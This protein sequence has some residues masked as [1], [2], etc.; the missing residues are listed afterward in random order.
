AGAVAF[1]GGSV[2]ISWHPPAVMSIGVA[3]SHFEKKI[4]TLG[5]SVLAGQL[6]LFEKMGEDEETLD[7][8]RWYNLLG[9]PSLNMR[10]S[11]PLDYQV[12][13]V[14]AKSADL[15]KLDLTAMDNS[16]NA[17]AGLT[18]AVTTTQR[19]IIAVG[20]TQADGKASLS[21]PSAIALGSDATLTVS[22]YN[23]KT[24]ELKLI[25]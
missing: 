11:S 21:L 2:N 14:I 15:V 16:G 23:A 20:T 8:L 25:N 6:Y 5:G 10:T 18:V 4:P 13:K 24:V 19:G 22:G 17:V 9:D 1:Y 7:N 12:K 3:K